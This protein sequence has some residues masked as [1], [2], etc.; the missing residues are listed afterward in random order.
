MV[1]CHCTEGMRNG[2]YVVVV[3]DDIDPSD[4][5]QVIWAMS[6]RSDPRRSIDIIDRCYG[7]V[8]VPNQPF[9]QRRLLL[10][11]RAIIDACKPYEWMNDFP[12]AIEV[13]PEHKKRLEEKWGDLLK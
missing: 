6:S 3:D 4:L 5:E 10:N 9:E 8:A 12:A 11:S 1:A 7:S 2:N 13:T